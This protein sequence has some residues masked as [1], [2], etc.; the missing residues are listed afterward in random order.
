[1]DKRYALQLHPIDR[2]EVGGATIQTF[3]VSDRQICIV[4][5]PESMS[6]KDVYDFQDTWEK[7]VGDQVDL[8]V[9]N[10]EVNL[11]TVGIVE[12]DPPTR[13]EREPLV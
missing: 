4:S 12:I 9:T 13:F 3:E 6:E 5:L 8:I 1:M 11:H 7:I 2:L 10:Y